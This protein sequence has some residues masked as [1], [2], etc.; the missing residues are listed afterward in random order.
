MGHPEVGCGAR[1]GIASSTAPRPGPLLNSFMSASAAPG[2]DPAQLPV[3]FSRALSN[4]GKPPLPS[5]C[6]ALVPFHPRRTCPQH[7]R[8]QDPA[9]RDSAAASFLA[10]YPSP[11][12]GPGLSHAAETSTFPPVVMGDTPLPPLCP[13][14]LL[15]FLQNSA[16]V[17]LQTERG[18]PPLLPSCSA[19]ASQNTYRKVLMLLIC[20]MSRKPTSAS[21]SAH[22]FLFFS[23]LF[24]ISKNSTSNS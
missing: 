7:P 22:P 5:T 24:K 23:G 2:A 15:L 14:K 6:T 10:F 18:P 20:L 1:E 4:Q 17:S 19:P 11:L 8:A 16:K 13:G 12:H 3:T 9:A 21:M